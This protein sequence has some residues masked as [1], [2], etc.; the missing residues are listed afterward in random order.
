MGIL[1]IQVG[2]EYQEDFA[3]EQREE[4]ERRFRQPASLVRLGASLEEMHP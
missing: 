3:P 2:T 1:L 4:A